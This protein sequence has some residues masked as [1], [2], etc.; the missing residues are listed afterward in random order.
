MSCRHLF[1]M[2]DCLCARDPIPNM[3]SQP[4]NNMH[5]LGPHCYYDC[6]LHPQYMIFFH[7]LVQNISCTDAVKPKV[8]MRSGNWCTVVPL[9]EINDVHSSRSIFNVQVLYRV[10]QQVLT[11]FPYLRQNLKPNLTCWIIMY[12]II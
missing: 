10:F 12:L 2:R 1:Q 6:V 8:W 3:A 9:C 5:F 7:L 11:C 4:Q